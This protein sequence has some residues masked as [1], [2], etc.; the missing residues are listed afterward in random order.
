MGNIPH[1]TV[2]AQLAAA[3][4]A[5]WAVFMC[6]LRNMAHTPGSFC[7][8]LNQ[9]SC[10]HSK[11]DHACVFWHCINVSLP[12]CPPPFPTPH[13][14]EISHVGVMQPK[15][16]SSFS[17]LI[18]CTVPLQH[19]FKAENVSGLQCP[20]SLGRVAYVNLESGGN[21]SGMRAHQCCLSYFMLSEV[22]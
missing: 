18:G 12:S 21:I 15:F 17:L 2:L 5:P 8:S 20:Q 16:N 9:L 14:C 10:W 13:N 4:V 3:G 22:W 19:L 1:L 6:Q 11:F 7:R